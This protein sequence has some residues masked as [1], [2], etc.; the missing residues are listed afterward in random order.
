MADGD[1]ILSL[2]VYEG[3]TQILRLGTSS[4]FS[5]LGEGGENTHI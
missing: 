2:T 5:P 3:G 4:N 1:V